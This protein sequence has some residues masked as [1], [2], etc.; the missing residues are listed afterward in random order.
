[1]TKLSRVRLFETPW[2]VALQAPLSMGF[3]RQEHW[4]GLPFPSSGDCPNPGIKPTSSALCCRQ[5]LYCWPRQRFN[6]GDTSSI[7]WSGTI[8]WRKAWQ[9][10]PAFLPGEFHGQRSLAGYS[11]WGRRVRHNWATSL[12]HWLPL[13]PPGKLLVKRQ[14]NLAPRA[15]VLVW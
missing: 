11:P 10:T 1:M 14:G 7:P 6:P 8:P 5:I 2:T 4:S 9:P 15:W 13:A 12:V 3:P